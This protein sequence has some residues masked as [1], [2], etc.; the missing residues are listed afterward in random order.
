MT[1]SMV[2]TVDEVDA[3]PERLD[4]LSL[5]LRD[6]LLAT[7]A[8]DV[9]RLTVGD[10]PPGTRGLDLVA[11]GGLVVTVASTL[12]SVSQVVETVRRW[13]G[14]GGGPGGRTVEMTLGDNH[15][16]LSGGSHD[17]QERLVRA[18]VEAAVAGTG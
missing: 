12:G 15:L 16:K 1:R 7:D 6:E 10:A 17:E 5:Q 13:L 2:L 11:A 3:D 14:G 18:F 8:E 4:V 9:S